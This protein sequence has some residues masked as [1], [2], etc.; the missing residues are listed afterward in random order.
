MD[1]GVD[2][3]REVPIKQIDVQTDTRDILAHARK[4]AT[5]NNFDDV[6]IVDIDSHHMEVESW[7]DVLKN[8]ANPVVR[9]HDQRSRLIP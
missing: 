8:I 9:D 2:G 1:T 5:K 6:F 3:S 4:Y 7:R